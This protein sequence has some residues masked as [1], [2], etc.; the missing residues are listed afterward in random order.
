MNSFDEW[1]CPN[2]PWIYQFWCNVYQGMFPL[3]TPRLNPTLYNQTLHF[4]PWKW[5][6]EVAAISLRIKYAPRLIIIIG[7]MTLV[8]SV[9][10]WSV[11][12]STD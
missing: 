8:T 6:V 1:F 12:V 4:A 10:F 9:I 7:L 5:Y 3:S 2:F 11:H